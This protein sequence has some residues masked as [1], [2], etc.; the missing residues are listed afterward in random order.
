MVW[1]KG[2]PGATGIYFVR[3]VFDDG[4]GGVFK[5]VG[6]GRF[7]WNGWGPITDPDGE[8]SEGAVNVT[9][10]LPLPGYEDE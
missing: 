8:W 1:N 2:I 7:G 5:E 6:I 3:F 4:N 9:G 10:W